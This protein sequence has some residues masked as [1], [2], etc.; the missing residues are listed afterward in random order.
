MEEQLKS[1]V[2]T[3]GLSCVLTGLKSV[4]ANEADKILITGRNGPADARAKV[5]WWRA[6]LACDEATRKIAA[7]HSRSGGAL[8]IGGNQRIRCLKRPA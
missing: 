2:Q 1:L 3:H 5:G 4:C 7:I 8:S 6:A